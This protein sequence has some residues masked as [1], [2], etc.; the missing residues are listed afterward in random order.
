MSS[1]AA[2][3]AA[4]DRRQQRRDSIVAAAA[5]IFAESGYDD[6]EME[7]VAAALGVAKGTIY[8][9][10]NSKQELFFACVDEGMRAMQ[11]AVFAARDAGGEPLARI[12]KSVRAYLEFF[13]EH[14]HFVELLMQERA[15]FKNRERPTYFKYRDANRGSW[16]DFYSQLIANGIVRGDLPLDAMLDMIGNLLYGTMFTNH[17]AGRRNTL[18][19]QHRTLLEV[20]FGGILTE[21]A[22]ANWRS[23]P[24]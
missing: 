3:S 2:N 5:R 10:F 1:T 21:D 15:I 6:T 13:D 20:V 7:R 24:Q 19:E 12:S 14:P 8:L 11:Q 22:Y 9:Y 23:G 16:R 4:A 18:D 17:F